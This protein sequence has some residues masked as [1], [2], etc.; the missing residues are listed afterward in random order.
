MKKSK[1]TFI[2]ICALFKIDKCPFQRDKF[3]FILDRNIIFSGC[4]LIFIFR[5]AI[6]NRMIVKI[7]A[8]LYVLA[9]SDRLTVIECTSYMSSRGEGRGGGYIISG[10]IKSKNILLR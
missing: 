4:V 1:N 6:V 3:F 8:V 2:Y 7:R 5:V 9:R 10:I